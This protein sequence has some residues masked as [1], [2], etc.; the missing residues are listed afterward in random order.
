MPDPTPPVPSAAPTPAPGSAPIPAAA[1]PVA[2]KPPVADPAAALAARVAQLGFDSVEE[3]IAA[4]EAP[5][6]PSDNMPTTPAQET[7]MPDPATPAA[8]PSGTQA[9]PAA[10]PPA[11]SPAAVVAG[12]QPGVAP[13]AQPGGHPSEDPP[14]D[15]ALP[16]SVRRRLRLARQEMKQKTT[17]AEAAAQAAAAKLTTYEAQIA[18]MQAEE[19]LKL[20]L[21]RAGMQD[22]DFG[23]HALKQHLSE[24]GKDKTPEGLEKLRAFD[25]K[26]WAA[27]QRR[28]RPYLFGEQNVPANTGAPTGAPPPVPGAG[29]VAAAAG[30]AGAFDARTATPAEYQKRMAALGVSTSG[31]PSPPLRGY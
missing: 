10:A 17:A 13:G 5:D 23:W 22:L 24:L 28:T 20:D 31:R 11:P 8:A 3:L 30:G 18:Q 1:V 21:V 9:T 12:A 25:A 19:N 4:L 7:V 15:R 27:D 6:D 14:E 2:A 26:A 16:E 29:P